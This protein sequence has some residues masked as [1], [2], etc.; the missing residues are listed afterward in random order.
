M[1]TR[2]CGL[3]SLR[4]FLLSLS[5]GFTD[6]RNTVAVRDRSSRRVA[7]RLVMDSPFDCRSLPPAPQGQ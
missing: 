7:P 2:Q 3:R 5:D 4:E 6:G 1:S